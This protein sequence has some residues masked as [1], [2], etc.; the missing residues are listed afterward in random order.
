MLVVS[1]YLSKI[2]M[3]EVR[4][5]TVWHLK[6]MDYI[7]GHGTMTFGNFIP[8]SVLGGEALKK[9]IPYPMALWASLPRCR[10]GTLRERGG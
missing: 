3:R 6:Y 1:N 8:K 5:G 9:S 10:T 7:F 4:A 2:N